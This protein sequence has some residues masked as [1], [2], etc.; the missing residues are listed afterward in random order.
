MHVVHW[1]MVWLYLSIVVSVI[2]HRRGR[3][4]VIVWVTQAVLS[5]ALFFVAVR[6]GGSGFAGAVAWYIGIL[7]VFTG[8]LC[9]PTSRQLAVI[10]GEHGDHRRCQW[11]WEAVRREAQRCPHCAL[12]PFDPDDEPDTPA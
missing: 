11:C 12:P 4:A 7:L 6:A 2:A 3:N 5:F 8:L 1:M 10:F 9:A